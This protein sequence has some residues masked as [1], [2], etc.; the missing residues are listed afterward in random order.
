MKDII[1]IFLLLFL[2][3]WVWFSLSNPSYPAQFSESEKPQVGIP[4]F[5]QRC[6]T[7]DLFIHPAL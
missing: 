2:D 7:V 1:H 5:P 6:V 4:L 3:F